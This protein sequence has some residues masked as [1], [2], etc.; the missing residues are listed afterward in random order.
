M[1]QQ[2]IICIS[3]MAAGIIVLTLA[4]ILICLRNRKH[5]READQLQR[6]K[7][8]MEALN[9]ETAELAHHQ[10]LETIGT[11]TSSIAH[12]FNNLLTPIMG[13]SMLALEKI[14]P[15]EEDLYDSIVEIYESSRKAKV[16]V[17]RLSDLSR[18][19]TE[20]S[21]H[22]LSPDEVIRKTLD[23]AAPAQKDNIEVKLNLNCWDQRIHAGE[24]QL[25]QLFLNLFLNAF[26]AMEEQGGVLTVSTDPDE[27]N[28]LIRVADT[29]CG[30]PREIQDKIFD[31]FFTT[32]DTGRG[33]GLG[34]AIAAQ[35]VEDHHGSITVESTEGA[36][37]VFTIILPRL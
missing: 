33:T 4:L 27:A 5:L 11:L 20:T 32:K 12:E 7:E 28:L 3:G 6:R 23:I 19:H 8:A 16:L 34:L 29:G 21:F 30:I 17:S 24:I 13:Y 2:L 36:G 14:P 25:T 15:E 18:K 31:P 10:R 37:T 35:V 26:H 9:R 22:P 1:E